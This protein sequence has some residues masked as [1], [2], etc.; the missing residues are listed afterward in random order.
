MKFSELIIMMVV[1]GGLFIYT[2]QMVSSNNRAIVYLKATFLFI[3]YGLVSTNIWFTLKGEEYH[4]NNHSGLEPVSYS[5]E[6]IL[7]IVAFSIYNVTL[8][9]L[10]MFL[11]RTRPPINATKSHEGRVK[12]TL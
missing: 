1:Y 11:K 9:C 3:L 4:I 10:N 12:S 6:A 2:W 8:L 7:M 5:G